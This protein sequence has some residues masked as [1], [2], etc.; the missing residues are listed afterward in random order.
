MELTR[1]G[2][3]LKLREFAFTNCTVSDLDYHYVCFISMVSAAP[4]LRS[5]DISGNQWVTA[6]TVYEVIKSMSLI[7]LLYL[8]LSRHGQ[9]TPEMPYSSVQGARS[10]L[11]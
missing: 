2:C 10:F 9:L 7:I 6:D 1:K 4:E 5:V 8:R 3:T 11:L